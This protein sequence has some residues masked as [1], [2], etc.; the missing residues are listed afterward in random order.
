[1]MTP[2]RKHSWTET[3]ES[4]RHGPGAHEFVQIYG[5]DC[6]AISAQRVKY[7][8]RKQKMQDKTSMFAGHSG[9]NLKS[10]LTM[11]RAKGGMELVNQQTRAYR[12]VCRECLKLDFGAGL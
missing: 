6:I 1:M 11:R 3:G 10:T 12:Y 8:C 4:N 7:R 9:A 2:K 5:Y